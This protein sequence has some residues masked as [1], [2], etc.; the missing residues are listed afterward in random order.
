MAT[1]QRWRAEGLYWKLVYA[2]FTRFEDFLGGHCRIGFL[3]AVAS[4]LVSKL[5]V[6]AYERL[7]LAEKRPKAGMTG[8]PTE[9]LQ[10]PKS[11]P[12]HL[13][14]LLPS[15]AGKGSARSVARRRLSAD[16]AE[17]ERRD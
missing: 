2:E 6:S 10:N 17:L 13:T 12:S 3:K 1:A 16:S 4:A 15:D 9:P 11:G 14:C 7:L 5:I 8:S